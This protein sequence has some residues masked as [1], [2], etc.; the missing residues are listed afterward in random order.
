MIICVNGEFVD[1][2]Q[3]KVS[4]LDHGLLYGD[5][6]FDTIL[7]VKG[8][9]FWLEEHV[10]RLLDGCRRIRLRVPWQKS[11]LMALAA[12][13]FEKNGGD[14]GRIRIT[15]TRGAGGIPIH[16][17][18]NCRPNLIIF[19]SPLESYSPALYERGLR[20]AVTEHSRVYPQVKNLSF[21]PS[22]L[23]YLEALEKDAHEALFVDRNECV[24]EGSTFNV[25]MVRAGRIQ[26]P[27][28][29]I[30][31]GV[32]RDKVMELARRLGFDVQETKIPLANLISADEVFATGTTKGILPV[33]RIDEQAINQGR[34][35]E[36]TRKLMAAFSETYY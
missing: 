9:I 19:S 22:V 26:T 23:G 16:D 17:A 31:A 6:V 4:V 18:P 14:A 7:A 20:L 29:G 25:F 3:A 24:L 35:G 36:I 2:S 10:D 21:L 28:E 30:L 34:V 32:T 12:G 27:A 1:E 15:I 33:S 13:T 8:Q 11:E 5:G